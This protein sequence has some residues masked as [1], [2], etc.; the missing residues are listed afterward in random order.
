MS[1]LER[2]IVHPHT[3]LC[4]RLIYTQFQLPLH[5]HAE[6]ELIITPQGHGRQFVGETELEFDAGDVLLIGSNVPHLHLCESRLHP[7]LNLTPSIGDVIQFHPSILPGDM[8]ALPD[9]AAIY[10]LL[11]K[12]QYGIRFYEAGLLEELQ[13][14]F[15][16]LDN[17]TGTMRLITLLQILDRLCRCTNIKLF[18]PIAYSASMQTTEA[19]DPVNKVYAYLYTHFKEEVKLGD[20]AAY[21]MQNPAALC[22][23]FKRATDKSIF[24]ILADIRIEHAR[25]LLA[26]SSL[27][28]AQVAY[29]SG[30]N[31]VT[32]FISQFKTIVRRTPLQYREQ[33]HLNQ[34]NE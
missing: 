30:Y 6:Y 12:S 22:R 18:S 27:T 7:E 9:Y 28:V 20:I 21:V 11:Q 15:A 4:S 33:I 19:D 3:T 32:H 10:S 23:T 17:Q 5:R 2:K 26:Y 34:G 31:N 14:L 29:Q 25:R 24:Q 1:V 16:F 8:D 13:R